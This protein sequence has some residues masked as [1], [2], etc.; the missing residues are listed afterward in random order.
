MQIPEE[1]VRRRVDALTRMAKNNAVADEDLEPFEGDHPEQAFRINFGPALRKTF[2]YL[3]LANQLG[4]F[5][6]DVAEEVIAAAAALSF[7]IS[8]EWVPSPLGERRRRVA[9]DLQASESTIIR[10][11]RAGAELFARSYEAGFKSYLEWRTLEKEDGRPFWVAQNLVTTLR[12]TL[13]DPELV[14]RAQQVADT[15][16]SCLR[17]RDLLKLR[18]EAAAKELGYSNPPPDVD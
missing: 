11:E 14:E 4:E 1:T 17:D 5:D 7:I 8:P 13:G 6:H 16:L 15:L 9:E 3:E 12:E 10:R 18:I 2:S